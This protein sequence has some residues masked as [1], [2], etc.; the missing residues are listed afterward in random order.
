LLPTN[1]YR[2]SGARFIGTGGF[3]GLQ[4]DAKA[5]YLRDTIRRAELSDLANTVGEE[6]SRFKEQLRSR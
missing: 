3:V 6:P 2:E 5:A 1:L 4:C